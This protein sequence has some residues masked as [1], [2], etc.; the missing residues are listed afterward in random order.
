MK[1][2]VLPKNIT[3][4]E[5][6]IYADIKDRAKFVGLSMNEL[7]HY[8][9]ISPSTFSRWV[10]GH[11]GGHISTV[12]KMDEILTLLEIKRFRNLKIRIKALG[13]TLPDLCRHIGIS[14]A[15]FSRWQ[16]REIAPDYER[17]YQIEYLLDSLENDSV[18]NKAM[19]PSPT[20]HYPP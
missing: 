8:C 1:P 16:K 4:L 6:K 17:I 19:N 5:R 13:I 2:R 9:G 10:N 12:G 3:Q 7:C 18:E 20:S 11:N 14:P 15:D